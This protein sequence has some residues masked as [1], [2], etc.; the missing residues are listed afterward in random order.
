MR[1]ATGLRIAPNHPPMLGTTI[2]LAPHMWRAFNLLP[3]HLRYNEFTVVG[4]IPTCLTISAQ[5]A[6]EAA[7]RRANEPIDCSAT[8]CRHLEAVDL[9]FAVAAS[10]KRKH[11]A[12]PPHRYYIRPGKCDGCGQMGHFITKCSLMS[13]ADKQASRQIMAANKA[14][15]SITKLNVNRPDGQ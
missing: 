11:T 4:D 13:E 1:Y 14:T 12:D 5:V 8:I 9:E 15:K 2:K 7:G 6:L 10:D 3:K